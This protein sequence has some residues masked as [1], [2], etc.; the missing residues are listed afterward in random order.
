LVELARDEPGFF[1]A[2]ANDVLSGD[3]ETILSTI[4]SAS[5]MAQARSGIGINESN[6]ACVAFAANMI[7]AVN[8]AVAANDTVAYDANTAWT[9]NR[10]WTHPQPILGQHTHSENAESE[11]GRTADVMLDGVAA[12]LSESRTKLIALLDPE[13]RFLPR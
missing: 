2:F 9:Q 6:D 8:V 4:D 10:W 3:R 11:Y 13:G 7:L 5:Q 1:D 12:D